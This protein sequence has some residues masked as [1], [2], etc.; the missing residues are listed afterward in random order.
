MLAPD[1][2]INFSYGGT[3][4]TIITKEFP[5]GEIG[6]GEF[7]PIDRFYPDMSDFEWNS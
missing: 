5:K 4:I 6:G 3:F 7:V 1:E 2:L